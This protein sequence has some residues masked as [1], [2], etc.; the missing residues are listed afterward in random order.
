MTAIGN[1]YNSQGYICI[2]N[3]KDPGDTNEAYVKP[4]FEGNSYDS[5][6]NFYVDVGSSFWEPAGWPGGIPYHVLFDKD[7]NARE[8]FYGGHGAGTEAF[9]TTYVKNLLGLP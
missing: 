9:Y 8:T 7:G 2:A 3:N 6:A 4:F 1:T 5:I